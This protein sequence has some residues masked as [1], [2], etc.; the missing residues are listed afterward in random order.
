[1]N[2]LATAAPC[3]KIIAVMENLINLTQ[4]TTCPGSGPTHSFTAAEKLTPKQLLRRLPRPCIESAPVK[5][6]TSSVSTM[7]ALNGSEKLLSDSLDSFSKNT[8]VLNTQDV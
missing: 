7:I 2:H 5:Y 4:A 3:R 1:M 8:L 6:V